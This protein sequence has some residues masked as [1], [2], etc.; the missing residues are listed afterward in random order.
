VSA[1]A[2]RLDARLVAADPRLAAHAASAR[3]PERVLQFGEGNFLRAFADWMLQRMNERGLF[4]GRAVIVQPLPRGQ[5]DALA[6]QD[7]LFTVV[8]RGLT[9]GRRV[10][11]RELVS[12]VSRCI[13]PYRDFDAFLACARNPD[14][15]FVVSNT[16]EAGIR[17]DPA[18]RLDARP[19]ASFPG[20]LTQLLEARCRHFGGDPRR[21]L[22]VLPCELIDR[23][24]DAL[25]QAVLETARS[26]DLPPAFKR[27]VSESCVFANTLVDRIV[28][29]HPRDE[30]LE[31]AAH[32]GY[33]DELL[34]AGEL[35]HSWVIEAPASLA[36]EL[37]L[38]AAGIDVVETRD[39]QPY[40]ERKVR[41]L[42]GAHTLMALVGFLAGQD[43]VGGCMDDELVRTYVERA[44]G[45]EIL[46]TIAFPAP[47][48]EAFAASVA[49]R[50]RN[51]FIRHPLSAI[52]LNSVSKFRARLLPALLEGARSTGRPPAHLTFAL[53]ALAAVYRA[54]VVEDG[55]LIGRR[56]GVPYRLQDEPRVLAFF[57]MAWRA[58][59]PGAESP[60]ACL[61]LARRLLAR[62]DFWGADLTAAV[63]GLDAAVAVFLHAILTEGAPAA[64]A[65]LVEREPRLAAGGGP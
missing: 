58:C 2:P 41:I 6:A 10:E 43:T 11:T 1:A 21:G 29:G 22:V 51:P 63:A 61:A 39:L 18:D 35:F 52:A 44:L 9:D 31:L 14:L 62:D 26:W 55:A 12:S 53:A 37:P 13:D 50:F 32:L 40:R 8:L 16:T 33:R 5:A 46:P 45:R 38:A 7:G 49:E 23:N 48:L 36:D 54:S 30:A 47:K 59:P 42:N 4:G 57:V 65:R 24:G 20:K 19:A 60:E 25:S 17:T 64:L 28:T 34:V 56:G 27:W 15:R 3:L